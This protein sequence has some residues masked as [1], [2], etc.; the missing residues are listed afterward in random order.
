MV[1]RESGGRLVLA[2]ANT[3]VHQTL[4]LTGLSKIIPMAD[5][6]ESGLTALSA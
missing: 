1:T 5:D 2:G 6:V 4:D 3:L